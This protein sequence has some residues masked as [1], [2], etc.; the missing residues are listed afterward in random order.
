MAMTDVLVIGAGPFGLSIST[1][2][3]NRGIEHTIVGRP[4][5]T[6]RVNMPL[7]LFLKSEPHGSV[8]HTPL[9]GYDIASYCKL[10]G[11]DDYVDRVGPLS[12]ERFLGYGDWFAKQLVP[13]V[14]DLTVTKIT[15]RDGGFQV[16]FAEEGPMFARQVVIATGLMP[17]ARVPRE[18]SHLPS[19]LMTHSK[20]W[21][22][23]SVLSGKR[24]AVLGGGQSSLQTAAL[25]HETGADVQVIVRKPEIFWEKAVAQ[26]IGLLDYI[27]K[28]PVVLCD[29]WACVAYGVP[30]VFRLMPEKMRIH[31]ALSTFGPSGAWWLRDRVEGILDVLTSH[32]LKSAEAHGSG[33]RLH[34]DGPRASTLDVDHVIAGTGYHVDVKALPFMS[35]EIRASIKTDV[36]FARVDRAGQSSVPGLY[37]AGVHTMTS[38]GPGA[39]FI[40]GTH[41]MSAQTV[42]SL[43]RRLR[44]GP[45]SGKGAAAA[46]T[47]LEPLATGAGSGSSH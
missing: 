38:L 39:R 14:R 3:R 32:S 41:H 24:V 28:P 27:R 31:K 25:L 15:P 9:K 11:Y 42:S 44:K 10:H 18:L 43:A 26:E 5:N 33:V 12:L 22:D 40:A 37:F 4:M 2:L 16:E 23:L 21:G 7:G 47:P 45:G 1:H 29:G 19:D 30:D 36:G 8:I 46:D 35:D 13:D 34:L 20:E 17:Y 6:W